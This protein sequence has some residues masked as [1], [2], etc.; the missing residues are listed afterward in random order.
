MPEDLPGHSVLYP[1]S[2]GYSI[3]V[4]G[5]KVRKVQNQCL[6]VEASNSYV[7]TP[8]IANRLQPSTGSSVVSF[9]FVSAEAMEIFCAILSI[10]THPF[11][12]SWGREFKTITID[13][14]KTSESTE[15]V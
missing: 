7:D 10:Y 1:R 9:S 13:C 15:L 8:E 4:A 6:G 14:F 2:I 12:V 11:P 3:D 5:S